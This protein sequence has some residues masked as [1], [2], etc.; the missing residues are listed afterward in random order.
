[1]PAP[2]GPE[3][4]SAERFAEISKELAQRRDELRP[5]L[6]ALTDLRD[7]CAQQVDDVEEAIDH[8]DNAI[9]ALSRLQ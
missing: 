9:D 4:P 1:M 2:T 6:T 8:L 5:Q 7:E 3:R